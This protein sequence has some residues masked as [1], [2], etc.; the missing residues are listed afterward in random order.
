MTRKVRKNS[1][2]ISKKKER[3]KAA[4]KPPTATSASAAEAQEMMSRL[5]SQPRRRRSTDQQ[6]VINQLTIKFNQLHRCTI[7]SLHAE[8]R[9]V[10][11]R[12]SE[13]PPITPLC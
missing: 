1:V 5:R 13:M 11:S 6:T 2:A 10:P 3:K 8:T 7:P 9:V 4:K 12:E